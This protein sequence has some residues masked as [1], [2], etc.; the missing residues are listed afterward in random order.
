MEIIANKIV[1]SKLGGK[2]ACVKKEDGTWYAEWLEGEY[3]SGLNTYTPTTCNEYGYSCW[4]CQG[5]IRFEQEHD[6]PAADGERI[7]WR[8]SIA[9]TRGQNGSTGYTAE[10]AGTGK[11]AIRTSSILGAAVN[12][13]RATLKAVLALKG[14]KKYDG[15]AII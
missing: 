15:M 9:S 11:R 8:K 5:F 1:W 13:V 4:K 6:C 2:Y 7:V 12:A 10:T 14:R 3:Y